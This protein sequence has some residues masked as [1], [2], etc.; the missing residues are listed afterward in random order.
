MTPPACESA[1]VGSSPRVWGTRG[2][3]RRD[4]PWSR[5]IPTCVGNAPR[6]KR[7]G[8]A[9]PVHPHVCGERKCDRAGHGVID[10]SSPRVWGTL[11]AQTETR[12]PRP[13]HPHVCGERSVS[14][15][16]PSPVSG[17]SPRVWGTRHWVV[18]RADTGRFIPTC[19]GNASSLASSSAW[20]TVHPHVCGERSSA[21][22]AETSENGSSPRVWGTL[23][24]LNEC[25]VSQR[26]IP[27]C[28]G[29]AAAGVPSGSESAVH[30][31]VCGERDKI[32][33][34]GILLVRFIPTCVGNATAR[35]GPGC[36]APVHPHV[37]G[38]RV[39]PIATQKTSDGSS[40]R[41]WGT[42][43]PDRH[44]KDI[45][46]FIPTC[47]GNARQWSGGRN[48]RAVHPHVCGERNITVNTNQIIN[49]SSPR[50][51]GTR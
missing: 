29:N 34:L 42:R 49:G 41:V 20:P 15:V 22:I 45:G 38:E 43:H 36:A 19:V 18:C 44:A 32:A 30:P 4:R 33:M 39:T 3:C 7:A 28:V 10:G 37:C 51:W 40:P 47:V 2:A 25:D 50:V 35:P 12:V 27:T 8:P 23:L 31:H 9:S 6:Q 13:V 26:F 17:S 1:P 46:R 16:L 11:P 5:F 14:P 24:L 21:S 48:A